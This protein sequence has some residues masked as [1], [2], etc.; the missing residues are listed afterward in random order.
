MS[1]L[2]LLAQFLWTGRNGGQEVRVVN[3]TVKPNLILLVFSREELEVDGERSHCLIVAYRYNRIEWYHI[4]LTLSKR[5]G[6]LG[7]WG[8]FTIQYSF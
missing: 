8:L 7:P 1:C 2:L 6:Q 5:R 3:M 4:P